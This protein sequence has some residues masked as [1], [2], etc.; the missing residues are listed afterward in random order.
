MVMEIK[1]VKTKHQLA[2]VQ[3]DKKTRKDNPTIKD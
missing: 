1:M 2:M 3:I